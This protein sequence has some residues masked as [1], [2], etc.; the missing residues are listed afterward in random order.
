M[1]ETLALS[2]E[3]IRLLIEEW[4]WNG[5]YCILFTETD[6]QARLCRRLWC[7]CIALAASASII[8]MPKSPRVEGLLAKP[9]GCDLA[10]QSWFLLKKNK[11]VRIEYY[12][13]THIIIIYLL[14]FEIFHYYFHDGLSMTDSLIK[15]VWCCQQIDRIIRKLQY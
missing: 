4:T 11:G 6:T 10:S 7:I 3:S 12:Y 8:E 14:K 15:K 13:N 5:L 2:S 9:V 1:T